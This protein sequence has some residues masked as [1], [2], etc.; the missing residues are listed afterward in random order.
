MRNIQAREAFHLAEEG[1]LGNHEFTFYCLGSTLILPTAQSRGE[2]MYP[3]I[4]HLRS[5]TGRTRF[6]SRGSTIKMLS[7][8]DIN[9]VYKPCP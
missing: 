7:L 4:S 2:R 1:R 3:F 5:D 6:A 8:Y 9:F